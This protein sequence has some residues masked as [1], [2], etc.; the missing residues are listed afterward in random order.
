MTDNEKDVIIL[1]G[2]LVGSLLAIYLAQEKFQVTVFEKRPDPRKEDLEAGRSI[3]LA[4]SR[5]GI[6][7]LRDVGLEE[8][9]KPELIPM[10]GRIMHD[11]NGKT[12]Y[13]PYGKKGQYINSVSRNGLNTV[14]VKEAI[15]IGVD[16]IFEHVCDRVDSRKNEVSVRKVGESESTRHTA[17]LVIGADGAFSAMR[18]SFQFIPRF[19]F[20][21]SYLNHGYTEMSIPPKNGD[22]AMDPNGLHIWPRG[23]FMFIALPNPDKS[24]TCT[25]FYPYEGELSF[26]S[27]K[28]DK[29]ILK[30]FADYFPDIIPLIPN[31]VDEFRLNPIAHLV[32][33]NS[34][35][36]A[37]NRCM[38]IGDASHAIV[39]FYGQGMN[40]GFEDCYLFM[41][42]AKDLNYDWDE[43]LP[44][45][46]SE[47]KKDADAI[48][49]LA[50]KNF[51]EMRD[52]VAD[53]AFLKRKK[54]EAAIHEL[55][56]NL[57]VPQYSMVTFSDHSYSDADYIGKL[58]DQVMNENKMLWEDRDPT[59]SDLAYLAE[60]FNDLM[61]TSLRDHL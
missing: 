5:R 36:W 20:R 13:Q 31:L 58:Q 51:I 49:R 39:P 32:T 56:P 21:Q 60:K 41:R 35:P 3:N 59:P 30:F 24:F 45:F 18:R 25:L 15:K 14:L 7:A 42:L 53:K 40:S 52:K 23:N 8:I 54:V 9:V 48:S 37:F 26:E 1:G 33:I 17:S 28:D 34:F 47:R 44:R 6:K 55:F 43:I 4:L 57:W 29:D 10:T 11:K 27:L 16:F 12:N 2:G 22:F 61:I 19:D 46:S 38:L 50:L